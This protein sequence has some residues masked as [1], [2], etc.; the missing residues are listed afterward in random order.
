[1][2]WIDRYRFTLTHPTEGARVV[3]PIMDD[4]VIRMEKDR[5]RKV[6]FRKLVKSDLV[7]WNDLENGNLDFDWIDGIN[8]GADRCEKIDL[9]VEVRISGAYQTLGE[10]YVSLND[11][12]F[13]ISSCR[14]TLPVRKKD[15]YTCIEEQADTK[16]N[17]LSG[18]PKHLVK[19]QLGYIETVICPPL[20]YPSVD[21]T[22]LEGIFNSSCISPG[23]GW[24][25]KECL[26]LTLHPVGGGYYEGDLRTTW[27]R[28]RMDGLPSAPPGQGW[29]SLG[30]GTYVRE[31][32]VTYDYEESSIQ[33]TP[34]GEVFAILV[35]KI[36]STDVYQNG[37]TLKTVLEK[38]ISSTCGG[39]TVKSKFFRINETTIPNTAPY[40][41]AKLGFDQIMVFQKSDIVRPTVPF[42][43]TRLE[44]SWKEM[45]EMLKLI[46][47]VEW[48][49]EGADIRIEHIS[50]FEAENG[51]DLTT[52]SFLQYVTKKNNFEYDST[53]LPIR[54]RWR[55]MDRVSA[56]FE[57]NDIIYGGACSSDKVEIADYSITQVTTDVPFIRGNREDIALEG[58]VFMA[59]Y[60]F[61]SEYAYNIEEGSI[62]GHLAMKQ[63]HPN[64]WKHDRPLINGVMNGA[65]T[66]FVSAKKIKKQEGLTVKVSPDAFVSVDPS[67]LMKTEIGWG[68]V[69]EAEWHSRN[70]M[71]E[72]NLNHDQ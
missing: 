31:V 45:M 4:L 25:A 29:I 33:Y 41:A 18:T 72:V 40:N 44:T 13:N 66:S 59:V 23:Q 30:G 48:K 14:V 67:E 11:A 71:I 2:G 8:S 17:V 63:L 52:G 53:E 51:L 9:L 10:G 55:W 6:I 39:L 32:P 21:L 57:G 69:Q 62:N 36:L 35:W 70:C 46:F 20:Y 5:D 28:E 47:N 1:M 38:I 22:Q 34:E 42:P 50:Y 7:L 27:I 61:G 24:V 15:E 49:L 58:M 37:V 65:S 16:V 26:W 68:E 43:A 56:F 3:F 60:S 12:K 54:E 64:Y 19:G